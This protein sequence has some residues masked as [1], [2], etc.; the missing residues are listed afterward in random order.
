M[1]GRLRSKAGRLGRP[2]RR[3]A[4]TNRNKGAGGEVGRGS[5]GEGTRRAARLGWRRSA[6][7]PA[8]RRPPL[9]WLPPAAVSRAPAAPCLPSLA[10][11]LAA[12][13]GGR[14]SVRSRV[15][16]ATGPV[17][18]PSLFIKLPRAAGRGGGTTARVNRAS[19]RCGTRG[20]RGA[21][22]R[23]GTA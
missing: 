15:A 21:G 6:G 3:V 8:A 1:P 16:P 9:P 14:R 18:P 20:S 10:A 19:N 7:R 22:P 17:A 4:T 12:L 23:H 13:P 5:P 11:A 2:G